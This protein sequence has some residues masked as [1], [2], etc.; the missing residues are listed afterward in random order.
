MTKLDI[1]EKELLTVVECSMLTSIGQK[2]L[3]GLAKEH[4]NTDDNFIVYCGRKMLIDKTR[5]LNF[6]RKNTSI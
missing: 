6:I 2:K 1:R 5:F 3:R 4:L